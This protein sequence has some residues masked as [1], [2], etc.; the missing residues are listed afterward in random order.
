MVSAE[1]KENLVQA[2]RNIGNN[3]RTIATLLALIGWLLCATGCIIIW[4][5]YYSNT[6]STAGDNAV[7]NYYIILALFV[8]I[9]NL[10]A[11][12]TEVSIIHF[13]V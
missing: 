3:L 1:M 8:P 6:D 12:L 13:L 4:H 5:F 9:L 7:T 11:Y 2:G 10:A